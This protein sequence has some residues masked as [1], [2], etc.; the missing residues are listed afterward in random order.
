MLY[1]VAPEY[2]RDTDEFLLHGDNRLHGIDFPWRDSRGI[3]GTMSRFSS[4]RASAFVLLYSFDSLFS[5]PAS[6][7]EKSISIVMRV[8]EKA[9]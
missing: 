2:M 4:S 7:S 9:I 8:K 1:F 5:A 3:E 6:G